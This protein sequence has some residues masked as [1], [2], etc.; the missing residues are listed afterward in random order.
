MDALPQTNVDALLGRIERVRALAQRL[1]RDAA[2]ADDLVQE[3]LTR[4]VGRPRTLQGD[5][6]GWIVTTL[7]NLA[8]DRARG[9]QRRVRREPLAARPEVAPDTL[10]ALENAERQRELVAAVLAL[11]EPYRGVVLL[12]FF[13]DLP[14]RAIAARTG[15]SAATGK[16]QLERGLA[17]LRTRLE[18]RF[19]E[20][21]AWAVALLPVV[22]SKGWMGPG[23]ASGVLFTWSLARWAAVLVLVALCGTAV[24]RWSAGPRANGTPPVGL[25]PAPL[26]PA[27]ES[28]SD[29]SRKT[30][31]TER[32][33]ATRV[34]SATAE[35]EAS[36]SLA[37]RFVDLEGA[38]LSGLELEWV[39]E[40]GEARGSE[41][42][43]ARPVQR[44]L[45]DGAGR[46]E[47][48]GV[49]LAEARAGTWTVL[50]RP[51]VVLGLGLDDGGEPHVVLAPTVRLA[52]RTLDTQGAPLAN[53]DLGVQ[54]S[55]AA[56]TSLPMRL[57][58][59]GQ[60]RRGSARSD[61]Q[62]RFDLGRVPT[63]PEF[64][65]T[66]RGQGHRPRELRVPSRDELNLELILES[67]APRAV[68][69]LH[70]W[71]LEHDGRPAAGSQ[72]FLG[73]D[74]TISDE[75]G[76][77]RFALST[78][79]PR[80]PLTAR[81]ADGRFTRAPAPSKEE[82]LAAGGAGPL[83]LRLPA[84]MGGL[85][86]RLTHG[87]GTPAAG[88]HVQ[89]LD[90]TPLGTYSASHEGSAP[91]QYHDAPIVTDGA[92]RFTL[93]RLEER[94]YRLR[95]LDPTTLF[96][97]DVSEVRPQAEEQLFVLPADGWLA[98]LRGRVVDVFDAPLGDVE[99]ALAAWRD[100]AGSLGSSRMLAHR[101]RT[102]G[103][104]R[105]ML[106][107]VPWRS[108][109]LLVEPDRSGP[110]AAPRFDLE[111]PHPRGELLLRVALS[112][113]V[114]ARTTREEDL[115]HLVLLDATGKSLRVSE[116][117]PERITVRDEVRR[118]AHGAFPLFEVS[119]AAT[120]VVLYT[121]E[122]EL[123]RIPLR[124]DP[125]RRNEL[126]LDR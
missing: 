60:F 114:V 53:V 73:Q 104:G 121:R 119:Q 101:T 111:D 18:G 15:R 34:P 107:D 105:F 68:P 90:P 24:V 84:G 10:R 59:A 2:A 118:A 16:K 76:R 89:P 11:D 102:D 87:D 94:A 9:E 96:V 66:V 62:G 99:V 6:W 28:T 112:C 57:R 97:H 88:F 44:V 100:L 71:V 120:S 37:L 92:G 36:S 85:S 21:G 8:R 117:H 115:T 124:L 78:W 74:S 30:T 126:D 45:S 55:I 51:L 70:G 123:R 125:L 41:S 33:V 31:A 20:R 116:R 63:H 7:R 69:E 35:P 91:G 3:A 42:A 93:P 17:Q 86:A 48:R 72:V 64:V 14:P 46:A 49:A 122:G 38:A 50:D 106:R 79:N 19:G 39:G 52:G 108:L 80:A 47:L 56:L 4:A 82:T 67:A 40:L 77:F 1:V 61:D 98:E 32:A 22:G 12:R 27:E 95:F 65:L 54:G 110:F 26:A 103:E 13:E 25:A 58:G 29:P 81:A 113:E 43:E 109:S 5:P 83:T 23:A 75:Q